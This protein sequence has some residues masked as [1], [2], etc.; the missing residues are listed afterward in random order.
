MI[1]HAHFHYQLSYK[2]PNFI[3]LKLDPSEIDQQKKTT[4]NQA[5]YTSLPTVLTDSTSNYYI[6][7]NLIKMFNLVNVTADSV[8]FMPYLMNE[9][10]F[11]NGKD[12]F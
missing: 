7:M 10:A 1:P 3:L 5:K 2:S 4:W 12:I 6:S 11:G 8:L 9:H